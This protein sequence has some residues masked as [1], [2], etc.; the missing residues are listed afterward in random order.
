[1]QN[2]GTPML[3]DNFWSSNFDWMAKIND[4]SLRL[5][6]YLSLLGP[7]TN[8]GTFKL[9]AVF[10]YSNKFSLILIPEIWFVRQTLTYIWLAWCH[11]KD[12]LAILREHGHRFDQ[13]ETA[14]SF[15]SHMIHLRGQHLYTLFCSKE[16][17]SKHCF[18]LNF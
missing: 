6:C 12:K 16:Y 18:G 9:K 7:F 13:S 1:M 15:I 5:F 17:F 3:Y 8:I 2:V 10:F 4:E 11:G 14:I